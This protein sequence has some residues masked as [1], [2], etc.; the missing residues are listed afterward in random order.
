MNKIGF[1]EE[2]YVFRWKEAVLGHNLMNKTSFLEK[3]MSFDEKKQFWDLIRWKNR[4]H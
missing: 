1:I 3:T 2:N 4:F